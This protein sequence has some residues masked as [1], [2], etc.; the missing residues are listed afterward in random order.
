M[1]FAATPPDI[2]LR[3]ANAQE[4]ALFVKGV[5]ALALINGP[6]SRSCFVITPKVRLT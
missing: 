1:I 2:A 6:F 4:A 3:R 5:G